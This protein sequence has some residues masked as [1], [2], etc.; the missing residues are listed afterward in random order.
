[1]EKLINQI[2]VQSRSKQIADKINFY[3]DKILK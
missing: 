2:N 3:S 1:M